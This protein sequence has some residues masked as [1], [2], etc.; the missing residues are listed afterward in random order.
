MLEKAV[1]NREAGKFQVGKLDM[2]LQKI[3]FENLGRSWKV[4]PKFKV[5]VEV[6][7]ANRSWEA[8]FSI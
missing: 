7:H 2:K 6:G 8:I 4:Q 1:R 5:T 3:K